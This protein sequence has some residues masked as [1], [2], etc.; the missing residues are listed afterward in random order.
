[1]KTRMN[2]RAR[3]GLAVICLLVLFAQTML[4]S[5]QLSLTYDEPIYTAIGYADLTT[6][7]VRF[8]GVIGHP[9]LV[10]LWTAWPLL[11]DSA[12]PDA[13]QVPNWGTA[14]SLGFSRALIDQLGPLE[15]VTLVT[16]LPTMWLALLLA[17]FV[18]RWAQDAWGGAAGLLALGLFV[19]DPH[20]VAHAQLNTTDLGVTAFGFIGCYALARYLRRPS[21]GAY[22]GAGLGLGAALASKASG[23]FWLGAYG[24]VV[25]AYWVCERPSRKLK[26]MCRWLIR[27]AGWVGLAL[28]VLWAAYLFELRPLT[29]GGVP[30]PAASH[31]AGL[32][33]I[34][35]YMATGQTTFLA[36]RLLSGGHW[37]YFPLT[38]LVKTPVPT[39]IG[40]IA[41]VL[42]SLRYGTGPR[43]SAIPLIAVPVAYLGLAILMALNIGHRHMLTMF[44]FAFV[45]ISALASE[46]ARIHRSSRRWRSIVL[47]LLASWYIIG[48]LAVFP[49]NLA[50]FNELVGGPD[51]GYRYL[52]DSSVDWGQGFKALKRYADDHGIKEMRLAAFS[53]LD[54]ALYDLHFEP[55]PP[56]VG[57]PITLTAR[58]NP[59][60]GLYVISAVPLQGVWV[61]DPDTY[62]W[63]RHRQPVA[64][65]GHALFVYDVAPD[66]TPSWV[67]QCA[68]P[69]APLNADQVAEGFG[70]SGLRLATFDCEWSWLYPAGGTGWIVLPGNEPIGDW[71]LERLTGA[72]V[73]FRQGKFWD[74]SALTIYDQRETP[75]G[76]I[77]PQVDVRVAPSHWPLD[78]AVAQGTI[79]KG[80]V[81]MAGPLAFL[82]YE[83]KVLTDSVELC[84][85]W[86]VDQL[87]SRP[88]SLMAHLLTADGKTVA[89][90]DGLGA[91]TE[92]W[93]P[94]D[95]IVQRHHLDMPQGS[96]FDSYYLQTGA[97]WLD[98]MERWPAVVDDRVVGDRILF[99]VH[100]R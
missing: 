75:T 93:Q 90:G 92:V 99:T 23:A 16:R 21:L 88:L 13:R 59:E 57:A 22:L 3:T 82:G 14:D 60:P 26:R 30:I 76:A 73:S 62:D 38:L 69:L 98:T 27:L 77:P 12:R 67:A 97:Y 96:V 100:S 45:F 86:R 6:G 55:I 46:R 51:S 49:N 50:Y 37:S 84:T 79:A 64:R 61:L 71:A 36:G 34:R 8:H 31:W 19:F 20:I 94:G 66:P 70:R 4:A 48:T 1:M 10:N 41:V 5:R 89:T 74:H 63:F 58:F 95:I 25:L 9:P 80:P 18:Y 81:V 83:T 87:P 85:Y 52:A 56:T 32:P 78:K 72:H 33:Y 29:S 11:L 65:V 53:S 44:P 91:P 24:L 43:W 42:W 68:A 47:G 39:L 40:L 15:R 2:R 7:D 17:A 35:S 54:P 28:L